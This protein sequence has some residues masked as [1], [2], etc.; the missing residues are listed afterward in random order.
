MLKRLF[1][2]IVSC[3]L[4]FV[5]LPLVILFAVLVKL[6][7]PG[8]AFFVQNRIGRNAREF[9][10]I[11]LRSMYVDKRSAGQH[12][13]GMSAEEAREQYLTTQENDPRITEIGSFLRKYHLD[14]LPQLINVLKGDMSLVGP[15][16]DAPV[17][18]VDYEAEQ[19]AKRH[20]VRPGITGLAQVRPDSNHLSFS[21]RVRLDLLY[22]DK[23]S[24]LLDLSILFRTCFKLTREHSF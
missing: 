6:D 18:E 21:E 20:K 4:I 14:E 12:I 22:V 19:W 9:G 15:R 2:I 10:M 23:A 13:P 5:S 1:D 8:P 11:K 7:S 24:I 17:Q 16:P 3:L